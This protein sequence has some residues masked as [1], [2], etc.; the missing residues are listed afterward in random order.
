MAPQFPPGFM[1]GAATAAYQVEGATD[2]D[3]RGPS[4]WDTFAHTPGKV[5]HGDTGDIACDHY[6][7]VERDLDSLAELGVTSY[8]FS[9]AWPRVVPD[10]S[11][12]TNHKGL[13][14]YRAHRRRAPPAEHHPHGDPLPLGFAP[15]VA[16]PRRLD[17][18]G[19]P[20][21]VR[22]LRRHRRR[23]PR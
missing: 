14:F 6:H 5:L 19:H 17:Q 3:G 8:R 22:R 21:P 12:D 10:G 1:F 23:R 20:A 7:R 4:I 18:P 11:G 16:A 2:E 9:V 15:A 13:D